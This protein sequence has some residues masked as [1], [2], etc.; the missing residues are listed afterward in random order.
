MVY[1]MLTMCLMFFTLWNDLYIFSLN[2][3]C[4]KLYKSIP[5][6]TIFPLIGKPWS[7]FYLPNGQMR[8]FCHL[9]T[10]IVQ[11][12]NLLLNG[13]FK[14]YLHAANRLSWQHVV[15]YMNIVQTY[16]K[17]HIPQCKFQMELCWHNCI[18]D[19]WQEQIHV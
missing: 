17:Y 18:P 6:V 14:P 2:K 7:K 8:T 1:K 9:C 19:E 3:P 11:A 12:Y 5:Q 4:E 10:A 15:R 13:N 16:I